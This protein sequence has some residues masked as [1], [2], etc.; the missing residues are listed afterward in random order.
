M[1][2]ELLT[3]HDILCAKVSVMPLGHCI[4]ESP[5]N[6][7]EVCQKGGRANVD[8]SVESR[9]TDALTSTL[10]NTIEFRTAC[11]VQ[12]QQIICSRYHMRDFV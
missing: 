11:L 7:I 3:S 9:R 8:R 2:S 1:G 5:M 10:V 12:Q 4:I 6:D